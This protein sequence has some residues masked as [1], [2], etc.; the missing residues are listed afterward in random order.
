MKTQ[1]CTIC[2]NFIELQPNSNQESKWSKNAKGTKR[3][4]LVCSSFLLPTVIFLCDVSRVLF[5]IVSILKMHEN[6]L[7][8]ARDPNDFQLFQIYLSAY[9]STY[10]L[11]N[12]A[13]FSGKTG[14]ILDLSYTF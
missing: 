8:N 1:K 4:L 7:E 10:S 6:A 9:L 12:L 14:A 5:S 11:T 2:L 13:T 3:L